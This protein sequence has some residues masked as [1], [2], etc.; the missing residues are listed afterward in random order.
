MSSAS[1]PQDNGLGEVR[2]ELHKMLDEGRKDAALDL[3]FGL[4][5]KVLKDNRHLETRV[6]QLLKRVYGRSSERIDPDQLKLAFEQLRAEEATAN[7]G[8]GP[9]PDPNAQVAN[10][11]EQ[12]PSKPPKPRK[13]RVGGRRSLPAHLEREQIRLVPT[14][15]QVQGKGVM[16]KVGE[17]SSEVLDYVPARFIV[18]HYIRETWS[19]AAGE[20]VTAPVPNKMIEKGIP[21][22]GLLTQ[23]VLSKYRDHCPLARQTRIYARSGVTLSR[24]TLV[25]WVRVVA[26][27]LQSLAAR[28]YQKAMDAHVLQVD[29]THLQVLDRSCVNNSKRGHLW[30]LVGDHKWVAYKYTQDWTAQSAEAF[31]GTRIGWMQIDGYAGYKGILDKGLALGVGCL[32]HARRYFVKAFEADDLRAAL[33]LE[34]I[35]KLYRIERDSKEA[36]ESP[37]QRHQRRQQH[38]VPILDQM[39]AWIEQQRAI[40]PPSSYL[41]KALT[42]AHNHWDLLRVVTC[43]GALE[44]DNGDVER[45]MRGPAMGRRNWLFAGSDEGAQRAAIILTILETAARQGVDLQQYLHDVLVKISGG[46]PLSRLDELL[47]Q[48]W[49][50]AHA[51]ATSTT[52]PVS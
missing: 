19:N 49:A 14:L 13:P 23:V 8:S 45:A 20:I 28:I 42:Y 5:D 12:E 39:E 6:A 2:K 51:Q 50:A 7:G 52:A 38:S 25:D 32:M 24:N 34:M 16:H 43:D 46:W 4:L 37:Q 36:A 41:G 27:L 29:D 11:P 3:V 15:E 31:L 26:F 9:E 30:A 35:R 21:G 18:L 40:E 17:Q 48:P 22:P 44:L 47:P 10:D 33:P 1:V